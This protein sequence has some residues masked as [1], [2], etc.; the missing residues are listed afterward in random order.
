MKITTKDEY[1]TAMAE[2]QPLFDRFDTLVVTD[3]ERFTVLANAINEW[4]WRNV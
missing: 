2:Y 1:E 4:E 3:I